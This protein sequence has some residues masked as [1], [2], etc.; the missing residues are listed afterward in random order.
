MTLSESDRRLL[1][2]LQGDAQRGQAEVGE[3][4]GMSRTSAWRRI[5]EFEASGLIERR[6]TILNPKMVG[7]HIH[8]VLAVTMTSH[9]DEHRMDFEAYVNRLPF[10]T[11]CFSV[12][13]DR[14]YMLHVIVPDI[15]TYDDVLISMILKHP[16]VA[17]ASSTFV[18]RRVKYTTELPLTLPFAAKL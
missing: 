5:R 15:G 6:V 2:A 10:V 4:A 8:V 16:A 13:G 17:S 12:A 7:L 18:L 1:D 11:E 9:A 3:I 14:D